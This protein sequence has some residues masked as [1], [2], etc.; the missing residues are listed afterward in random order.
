[1]LQ[2]RQDTVD[3]IAQENGLI[4]EEE[5]VASVEYLVISQFKRE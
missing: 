4:S 2:A 1:M 5:M 3:N